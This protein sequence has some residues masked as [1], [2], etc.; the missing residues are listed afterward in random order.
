MVTDGETGDITGCFP[1]KNKHLGNGWVALYQDAI[2]QIAKER[3]TGEQ[4]SVFLY[5]LGK[6][7]F[8]NYLTVNQTKMAEELGI[9]RVNVAKALKTLRERSII[10]E[11][12]RVGLNKTYRLNPY[13]AHK[14]TKRD[15]TIIDFKTALNDKEK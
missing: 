1:L 3:L 8:D 6:T 13:V 4:S 5:I 9:H 7:D 2:T 11:G 14:G 10:V 15:Q 12:P